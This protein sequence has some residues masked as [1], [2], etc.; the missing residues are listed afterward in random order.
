MPLID[1]IIQVSPKEK[2]SNDYMCPSIRHSFG[3]DASGNVMPCNAMFYSVGNIRDES[4]SV[5]WNSRQ[6]KT[7]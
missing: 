6:L 3:I 5:I 7:I 4:L 2:T 1:K